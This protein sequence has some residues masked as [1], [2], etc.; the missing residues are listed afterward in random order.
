VF[1]FKIGEKEILTEKK[2]CREKNLKFIL[3]SQ[4]SF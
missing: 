2:T 1:I 4:I 3:C